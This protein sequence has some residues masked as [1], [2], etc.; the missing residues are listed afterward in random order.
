VATL[1]NPSPTALDWFGYSVA[2]SGTRVVVGAFQNDTGAYNAGIAYVYEL[3]G[4]APTVPMLTL[5]NPGPEFGGE[6]GRSG[7]ISGTLV[8]FG[9]ARINTRWSASGSALVYDLASATPTVPVTVLQ[10]PL[11]SLNDYFGISVAVSGTRVVVGSR[12]DLSGVENAGSAYVFDLAGATPTLPVVTLAT[13]L[14]S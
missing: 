5:T 1:T 2:V 12:I 13:L 6:F 3:T 4:A 8:V 14:S 11:P 10:R 9:I 7:A